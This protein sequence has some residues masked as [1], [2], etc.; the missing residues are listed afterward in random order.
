F[1]LPSAYSL[2]AGDGKGQVEVPESVAGTDLQ[3]DDVSLAGPIAHTNNEK[4]GQSDSAVATS[5]ER[6]A[7]GA[8]GGSA[9]ASDNN[10][11]E[12]REKLLLQGQSATDSS[13]QAGS[14][15]RSAIDRHTEW[16]KLTG[17]RTE[18]GVSQHLRLSPVLFRKPSCPT[19]EV[20]ED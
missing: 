15:E 3:K 5:D 14:R 2:A 6:P 18:Q 4:P 13:A 7:S 11:I 10:A 9:A 17:P 1:Q 16:M 12:G 8:N 19:A 20:R